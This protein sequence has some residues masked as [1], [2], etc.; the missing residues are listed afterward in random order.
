MSTIDILA[1]AG[2]AVGICATL[3]AFALWLLSGR[4]AS[5]EDLDEVRDLAQEAHSKNELM[6]Q[7]IK[8]LTEAVEGLKSSIEQMSKQAAERHDAMMQRLNDL[9]T[10]T[11]VLEKTAPR[12][13]KR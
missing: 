1:A 4:F 8:S 11:T 10:R 6:S 5:K 13:R 2:T 3:G 7:P 12:P 9:H